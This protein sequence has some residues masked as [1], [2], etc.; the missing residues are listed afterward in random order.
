MNDKH[1]RGETA[2]KVRLLCKSEP[3]IANQMLRNQWHP[4]KDEASALLA[5]VYPAATDFLED[6]LEKISWA[7]A[8]DSD[9]S[10]IWLWDLGLGAFVAR[11]VRVQSLV[12]AAPRVA[13]VEWRDFWTR[14]GASLVDEVAPSIALDHFSPGRPIS[15]ASATAP[16]DAFSPS[17]WFHTSISAVAQRERIKQRLVQLLG[18]RA[19]GT[20]QNLYQ[21][22]GAAW[23]KIESFRPSRR[24]LDFSKAALSALEIPGPTGLHVVVLVSRLDPGGAEKNIIEIVKGLSSLGVAVTVVTTALSE[25][26]WATRLWS[27]GVEVVRLPSMLPRDCWLEYVNFLIIA[28]GAKVLHIMNSHWAFE[29]SA[30]LKKRNPTLKIVT[31]LHAEGEAGVLDFPKLAAYYDRS[32]DIHTV[33][34]Q[35][36]VDYME[37]N[38]SI[39][40][41]RVR[42]IRTGLSVGESGSADIAKG[43]WRESHGISDSTHLVVFVGRFSELKRPLLFLEIA[44]KVWQSLPE[45]RFVLKGH[46]P[47]LPSIQRWLR[48][49]CAFSECVIVEDATDPVDPLMADANVLVLPSVM[50]GI[51]F[52]SYEAMSHGLPQVYADVG[53]QRELIHTDAGV[54]IA[55]GDNEIERYAAAVI[56]LLRSTNKRHLMSQQAR[57]RFGKWATAED[58]A[59]A[60]KSLYLELIEQQS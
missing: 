26:R 33:I 23:R 59:E 1:G 6:S 32:I 11:V 43:D 7:L 54:P 9:V 37:K 10:E 4:K 25:D 38:Y 14:P 31:H 18:K 55:P 50:E 20:L 58:N 29:Q 30:G 36:L 34:S 21:L 45:S 42:L 48:S 53:G 17:R 40:G 5:S 46:G 8:C 39:A 16:R 19:A 22:S 60:Y 24:A 28:R 2:Y 49:E 35:H 13:A 57:Y 44:K 52:V 27:S 12:A 15:R 56:E 41:D 3:D 47:L 51:A